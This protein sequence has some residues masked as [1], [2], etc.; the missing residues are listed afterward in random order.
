MEQST[1]D[2]ILKLIAKAKIKEAIELLLESVP[3][4]KLKEAVDFSARFADLQKQIR[5]GLIE[6]EKQ[7]V[8]QSQI[9]YSII[10]SIKT[11]EGN[12]GLSVLVAGTGR[13]D[14]PQNAYLAAKNI[15]RAIAEQRW[16]LVCG[17]W[18]GVDYVVAEAF[19]KEVSEQG[20]RLSER[21]T[22]VV[23]EHQS[24]IFRGGNILEVKAGVKE[25]LE[26]IKYADIVI[27]IGG[28][29]GTYETFVLAHQEMRPV[30]PIASTGGDAACVYQ[31]IVKR[32]QYWSKNSF[33]ELPEKA[34]EVMK[35]PFDNEKITS[36]T[37]NNI[38]GFINQINRVMKN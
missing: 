36:R 26:A 1:K 32:W 2:A 5:L 16:N 6:Y 17:G 31:E 18:Q 24:P 21:L 12:A 9:I 14:L 27:I 7:T 34:F 23:A 4:H 35:E 10:E 8:T 28:E 3:K 25:W 20:Q 13:Y 37:T 29:G 38:I 11:L 30:I 19:A 15:G 33:N 22:Q